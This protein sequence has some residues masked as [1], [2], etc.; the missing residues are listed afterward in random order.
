MTKR[1]PARAGVRLTV[2]LAAL[3]AIVV[4]AAA[5]EHHDL[6]C[7]LKTPQHCTACVTSAVNADRVDGSTPTHLPLADLGRA[8][9]AD[10]RAES[11]VVCAD[12]TGRSPPALAPST[13]TTLM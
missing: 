10:M 4:L 8:T 2:A 7:E 3:Y 6:T 9:P 12:R 5:F 1:G 11:V 13:S